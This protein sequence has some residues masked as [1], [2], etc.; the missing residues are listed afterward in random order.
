MLQN[1]PKYSA[2][3]LAFIKLACVIKIYVMSIFEWSFYTGFAV[4]EPFCDKTCLRG[5]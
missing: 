1:A 3:L 5:F 2:I 4:I